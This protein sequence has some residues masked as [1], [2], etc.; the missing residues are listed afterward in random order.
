[1][2]M[3]KM[4]QKYQEKCVNMSK[5]IYPSLIIKF[6]TSRMHLMTFCAEIKRVTNSFSKLKTIKIL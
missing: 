1:M 5:M 6:R 3:M 4:T 2:M